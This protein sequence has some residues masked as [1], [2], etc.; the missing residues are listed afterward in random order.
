MG[1]KVKFYIIFLLTVL[2]TQRN[3][4]LHGAVRSVACSRRV[5]LSDLGPS[6]G[7]AH[8]TPQIA[9]HRRI[10]KIAEEYGEGSL[11][12]TKRKKKI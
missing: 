3:E 4:L 11:K 6:F 2:R 1:I 9:V 8:R 7:S 5:G 12:M 10:N